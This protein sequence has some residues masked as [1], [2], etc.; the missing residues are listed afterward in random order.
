M[1]NTLTVALNDLRIF[2]GSRGNI[3]GLLAIPVVMT[4][5]LGVFIPEGDGP[6]RVRIDVVDHDGAEIAAQ[7]LEALRQANASIVLCPMDNDAEDFCRLGDD[8]ALD[9]ARSTTRIEESDTLALIEIPSGFSAKSVRFEPVSIRFVSQEGLAGPDAA[10]QAVDTALTRINGAV[11]AARVGSA[12]LK[13]DDSETAQFLYDEACALWQAS[14]IQVRYEL[15]T[16]AAAGPASGPSIG[17]FGQSVPGMGSMF[18]MFTVLGGMIALIGEK[19]QWTLQ[20]LAAM[21]ISRASLLGGK[22][23]GRFVLGFLQYLVVFAV[24]IFAGLNFGSDFLALLLIML[25]FTL[26]VTALSFALGTQLRSESQAAGL[27]NLLGLTLAPLGGAWWPLE[28]V[29]EFMRIVGHLSPVAWAMD[30]YTTLL[31]RNGDLGEVYVPILVLTGMSLVLFGLG[32]R[33]FKY[34]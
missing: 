12:I 18:V 10:R 31:F 2:F 20:R 29:P 32:I 26:S 14:P 5:I 13:R 22:I 11:V 7:F 23:L 15:T 19:K 6:T 16:V 34:D 28:T 33:R 24:G 17:G 1:R 9:V 25:S 27:T 3:I 21:P 4:V 8:K 30:G